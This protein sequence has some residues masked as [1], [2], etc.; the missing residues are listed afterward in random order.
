VAVCLWPSVV[1]GRVSGRCGRRSVC[2]C[3]AR[4]SIQV[5]RCRRLSPISLFLLLPPLSLIGFSR[6]LAP[7]SGSRGRCR[8]E[9]AIEARR[10]QVTGGGGEAAQGVC[11]NE[12]ACVVHEACGALR[13]Q[14]DSC[15]VWQTHVHTHVSCGALRR[16][17]CR[18][19][20]SCVVHEA[21]VV[22]RG[23]WGLESE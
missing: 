17:A 19:A 18:Q 15:V 2:T 13:R 14:A 6:P 7:G 4:H 16:V 22:H 3:T 5:P 12:S 1:C 8:I 23:V 21:C 11:L 20:D 9:A 10:L